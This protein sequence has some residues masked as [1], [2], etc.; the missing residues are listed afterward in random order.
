MK[1][2]SNLATMLLL[3]AVCCSFLTDA[4]AQTGEEVTYYLFR[5]HLSTTSNRAALVI[6]NSDHILKSRVIQATC[7]PEN[8]SYRS[9]GI[10]LEQP[11]RTARSGNRIEVT[12]EYAIRPDGLHQPLD[13][14][15]R[16]T[17]LNETFVKVYSIS[18]RG[19]EIIH[20]DTFR[21]TDRTNRD[22]L[23]RSFKVDI[24]SLGDESPIT[25]VLE[26]PTVPKMIWAYYYTWYWMK[27]WS[28]GDLKD[29]PLDKYNSGDPVAMERHIDQAK[30]AGI[31]GFMF[32]WWGPDYDRK[33]KSLLNVAEQKDFK[34]AIYFETLANA[35]KRRDDTPDPD[36]ILDW[37]EHAITTFGDHP[38][39]MKV[40]GRPVIVLWASLAVPL[41]E[42]KIILSHLREKNLDGIF[43]SMSFKEEDL[44]V[45]DGLHKY[46]ITIHDNLAESYKKIAKLIHHYNLF[47]PRTESTV[48]ESRAPKIWAAIVTPG[49][50][51][52]LA[53][54]ETGF[55]VSRDEGQT[56]RQTFD[57]AIASDPDWIFITSWNEWPEHTYIE[58]SRLYG[59]KYLKITKEYAD[60]WK[61]E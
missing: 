13:V 58:P 36:I 48:S 22:A 41:D 61:S 2:Q 32:S 37:L 52:C 42:W 8:Y 21:V 27:R 26:R 57:A 29:Q 18:P 7:T 33:L 31:D 51:D 14:F 54:P 24:S 11:V 60:K 5:I 47:S 28:R 53:R 23:I 25:T 38:A 34:V 35:L 10:S 1:V 9:D 19:M 40:N 49:Y 4:S 20:E 30:S 17:P 56:Y 15:L 3:L 45:F 59:D 50:D 12:V 16:L 6:A 43:I 46:S 39:F 55:I 44:D